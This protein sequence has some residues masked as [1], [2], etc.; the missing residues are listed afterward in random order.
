[1]TFEHTDIDPKVLKNNWVLRKI[2]YCDNFAIPQQ[3][4]NVRLSLY[5]LLFALS[6]QP[7]PPEV[8]LL[9]QQDPC[10]GGGGRL[11][12]QEEEGLERRRGQGAKVSRLR[13]S[14]KG[15]E[16]SNQSLRVS[17]SSC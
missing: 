7:L 13:R 2:T 4:H 8:T 16:R 5:L 6:A 10:R 1:M 15:R 3:C 11:R 12:V 17:Q 14:L 9:Y